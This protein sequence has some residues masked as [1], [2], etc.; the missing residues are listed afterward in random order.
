MLSELAY[1]SFW[2]H[3]YPS[4]FILRPAVPASLHQHG[5]PAHAG[6]QARLRSRCCAVFSAC[7]PV[8]SAGGQQQHPQASNGPHRL[9]A[10]LARGR[11]TI[12]HS[13]TTRVRWGRSAPL[14]QERE[15]SPCRWCQCVSIRGL[16]SCWCCWV[17]MWPSHR[18]MGA[19]R[20]P[21]TAPAGGVQVCEAGTA[22]PCAGLPT[23]CSAC[24][25]LCRHCYASSPRTQDTDST[26][27]KHSCPLSSF[28]S[29]PGAGARRRR[30]WQ[31]PAPCCCP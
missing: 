31:L 2:L 26:N 12:L 22:V 24:D 4:G 13:A 27:R 17:R 25:G 10:R 29:V 15:V 14:R 7:L 23:C 5:G 6:L 30:L 1:T 20:R 28:L 8:T 9:W 21:A 11:V 18:G 16:G 19:E 3:T